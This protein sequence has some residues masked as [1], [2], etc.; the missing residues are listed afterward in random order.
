MHDWA[1]PGGHQVHDGVFRIPLGM[2]GDALHAVNVYAIE[3][4]DG[5]ALVD[6]GWRTETSL[7]ELESALVGAGHSATSVRDVFVT[8]V[9]RDHY[10][11]AVELRRRYGTRIGLGRDEAPGLHQ[12]LEIASSVPVTS[13]EQLRRSGD[14]A[15][16]EVIEAAS[17]AEEFDPESWEKP[18][19]WL[20]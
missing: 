18:D 16:A 12:L 13:L 17:A 9:H 14:A 20:E 1:E 19:S 10:T 6:G 8:H 2:P 7:A 15:L 5:L 3:T 11:L 4:G